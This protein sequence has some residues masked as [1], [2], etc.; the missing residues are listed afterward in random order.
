MRTVFYKLL[1]VGAILSILCLF[2]CHNYLGFKQNRN[3]VIYTQRNTSAA[4]SAA[5]FQ[6]N[7]HFNLH[8]GTMKASSFNTHSYD[9]LKL[10]QNKRSTKLLSFSATS[11]SS[12]QTPYLSYGTPNNGANQGIGTHSG[13]TVSKFQ[14]VNFSS[15]ALYASG[16]SQPFSTADDY[17]SAPQRTVGTPG[18]GY[19]PDSTPLDDAILPLMLLVA[20]FLFYKKNNF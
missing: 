7:D 18:A 3:H 13:I 20:G 2:V 11:T 8:H 12:S 19:T 6:K 9:Y 14:A 10:N 16:N 1:T 5:K 17:Y 4:F 15:S